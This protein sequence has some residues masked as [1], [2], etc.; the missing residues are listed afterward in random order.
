M[1][2]IVEILGHKIANRER[3]TERQWP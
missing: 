2:M 1:D 3:F